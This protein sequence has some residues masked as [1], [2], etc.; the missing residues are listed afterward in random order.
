MMGDGYLARLASTEQQHLYLVLRHNLIPLELI[1][2]LL[3]A[4]GGRKESE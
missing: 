3:V 4:W 2:D 1:L